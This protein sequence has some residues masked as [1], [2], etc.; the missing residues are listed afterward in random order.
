MNFSTPLDVDLAYAQTLVNAAL[1]RSALP[2][3]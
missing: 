1:N 2:H 3:F